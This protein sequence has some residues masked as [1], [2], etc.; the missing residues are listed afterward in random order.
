[1]NATRTF[2]NCCVAFLFVVDVG[3]YFPGC[4]SFMRTAANAGRHASERRRER[5]FAVAGKLRAGI[6]ASSSSNAPYCG[7][8]GTSDGVLYAY[9]RVVCPFFPEIYKYTCPTSLRRSIV[10]RVIASQHCLGWIGF[11]LLGVVRVTLSSRVPNKASFVAAKDGFC[12]TCLCCRSCEF[13][14]SQMIC[15]VCVTCS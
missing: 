9:V 14:A 8:G 5:R 13:H 1:M 7:F 15:P 2:H 4:W 11:V 6:Y 12:R 10:P 3:R